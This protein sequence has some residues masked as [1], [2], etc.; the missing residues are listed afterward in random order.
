MVNA[1]SQLSDL[2][3]LRAWMHQ[4]CSRL[5]LLRFG[6]LLWRSAQLKRSLLVQ[7]LPGNATTSR[8]LVLSSSGR[9]ALRRSQVEVATGCD[10]CDVRDGGA[11]TPEIRME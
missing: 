3:T 2:P 7:L 1:M 8:H 11:V 4:N 5:L 6:A 9:P 10:A